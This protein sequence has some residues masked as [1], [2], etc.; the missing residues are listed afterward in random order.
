MLHVSFRYFRKKQERK[1]LDCSSSEK[2]DYLRQIKKQNSKK[3][4]NSYFYVINNNF[5]YT[6]LSFLFLLQKYSY[7]VHDD[8]DVF[9]HLLQRAFDICL[10]P[11]LAFL[12]LFFIKILISLTCFVLKIFFELLIIV[13]YHFYIQKKS[14]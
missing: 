5:S 11:F 7:C 2:L 14:Y 8:T 6:Q 1:R 9:F 10:E 4:L 12:I 3:W 13:S